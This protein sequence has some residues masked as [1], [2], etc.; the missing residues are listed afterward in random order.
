MCFYFC[1]K[2]LWKHGTTPLSKIHY[3]CTYIFMYLSFSPSCY[4]IQAQMKNI[5][6]HHPCWKTSADDERKH[7]NLMKIQTFPASDTMSCVKGDKHISL[8]Q[9]CSS[10]DL[11]FHE[12]TSADSCFC[13]CFQF[14]FHSFI[15]V[16]TEHHLIIQLLLIVRQ[17]MMKNFHNFLSLIS[18]F[19]SLS[20]NFRSVMFSF[21]DIS[22]LIAWDDYD[23]WKKSLPF[24]SHHHDF[25][26]TVIIKAEKFPQLFS[27]EKPRRAHMMN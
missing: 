18:F 13:F 23:W 16:R 26:S 11:I 5:T 21:S 20:R 2:S 4:S 7:T 12:L 3:T 8:I 15:D 6:P 17:T 14:L 19:S 1:W 24:F 22:L 9:L 27:W 25:L 10:K